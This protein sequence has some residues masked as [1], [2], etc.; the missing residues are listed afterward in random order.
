MRKFEEWLSSITP[1]RVRIASLVAVTAL[2]LLDHFTTQISYTLPYVLVCVLAAWG[3]GL[4]WGLTLA[5]L[6]VTA[7]SAEELLKSGMAWWIVSLNWITRFAGSAVAVALAARVAA[8][9]R[10]LEQTVAARPA[11]L[12]TEVAQHRETQVQLRSIL[13]RFEELAAHIPEVFWITDPAKQRML[14]LSPAYEKIWGLPCQSAYDNAQSWLQSVHPEDRR[15]VTERLPRQVEGDYAEH[16]R[17]VQPD[18][19]V[20]WIC[21]RAFPVRDAQGCVQRLVG[22]SSDITE[23]VQTQRTLREQEARLRTVV[24]AAPVILFA[25]DAA[26]RITFQE[27]QGLARTGVSGGADLGLTTEQACPHVPQAIANAHRALAGEAV[28][29]VVDFGEHSFHYRY[30]PQFD[31]TG[32]VTGVIG[33]ATDVTEREQARRCLRLEHDAA[34]ALAAARTVE[35]AAPGLLE[36]IGQQLGWDFTALWLREPEHGMMG[37]RAA[38]HRPMATLE[39]F[40]AAVRAS[41]PDPGVGLP[42]RV[43]ASGSAIWLAELN[44]ENLPRLWVEAQRAQLL[45]AAAFPIVRDGAVVGALECFSRV[46]RPADAGVVETLATVGMNLSQLLARKE[47]EQRLET[48]AQILACL[49]EGVALVEPNSAICLTNPAFDQ[50]FG[51]SHGE[52]LGLEGWTLID[53]PTEDAQ[54]LVREAAAGALRTGRW[55]QELPLRKRCDGAFPSLTTLSPLRAEGPPRLVVTV[56]DRTA[57]KRAE[58]AL[59]ASEERHRK[60]LELL[61]HAC[62]L[63]DSQGRITAANPAAARL[64]GLAGV[65]EM[66][67]QSFASFVRPDQHA[68]ARAR[69]TQAAAGQPLPP[70]AYTLQRADGSP[71]I[72]E[73]TTIVLRDAGGAPDGF[74]TLARDITERRRLEP[75][76][77]EISDRM[78]AHFGQEMHDGLCPVLVGA[79]F[80]ASALHRRLA[81]LL[82]AEAPALARLSRVLEQAITDASRLSRGLFPVTLENS[83]LAAALRELA[84]SPDRPGGLRGRFVEEGGPVLLNHHPAA[85]HLFR[86]AQEA[87]NNAVKHS[88]ACQLT[89][90]LLQAPD[91]LTMTVTDDGVGLPPNARSGPGLGLHIMACRARALGGELDIN[92]LPDG[93]TEVRCRLPWPLVRSSPPEPALRT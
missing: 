19:T 73:V 22:F 82:P 52:M 35:S 70:L 57:R 69:L 31:A 5:L 18:G 79:A 41:A 42:G 45:S 53:R 27:G 54:T 58:E 43:G 37:I 81:P 26:G 62:L 47:V 87:L 46:V 8:H 25:L 75:E 92:P 74:I 65:P 77:I 23:L 3:A 36:A 80:D 14:Y 1:A 83:A 72:A 88:G 2:A 7:R 85:I 60:L 84:E 90:R 91:S 34:Q 38:W 76:I 67:G 12:A 16:Y 10:S 40:A 24:Q 50:M 17:I 63:L 15:R 32:K 4:R 56:L 44:R 20:R 61:P 21:D 39:R 49:T 6:T 59:R 71:V 78:Q 93:G 29:E 30:Q 66:I 11:G 28:D 9:K 89:I 64:H 33:V 55:S 68:R 13:E 51:Y 48:Q 86:I